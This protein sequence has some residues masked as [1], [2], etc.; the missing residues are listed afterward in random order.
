MT[1]VLSVRNLTK[2]YP[3]FKLD[4]VSFELGQGVIMGFI[5]RNGAGKT[6]TLKSILNLVHPSSGEIRFFGLDPEKNEYE[7]KQ[8]IGFSGGTVSWFKKKKIRDIV[9][10][11]KTF[12][13]DWDDSAFEKYAGRFRI[14]TAK[15]PEQLSEGMKVKLNLALALSHNAEL[16]ILDEPTSGLDP[17]SRE[18]LLEIFLTLRDEGVSVLFSTHITSDLEKCA[19]CIT[20]IKNGRIVASCDMDRFIDSYRIVSGGT[21][22]GEQR[23]AV[24]GECMSKKGDTRLV[25]KGDAALFTGCDIAVPTLEEIMVHMDKEGEQ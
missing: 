13:T 12:Y 6:T 2:E 17:V 19:D 10:V 11:T 25:R 1:S 23:Q 20:Y 3:A 9:A 14:D 5:G 15:T 18:E 24:I 8:R 16:L 7:I 21:L 4:S 22:T